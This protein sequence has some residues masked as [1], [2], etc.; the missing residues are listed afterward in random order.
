MHGPEACS[1]QVHAPGASAWVGVGDSLTTSAGTLAARATGGDVTYLV[2]GAIVASASG[3]A[4]VSLP[5]P[6]G[7]CAVVRAIVGRSWS[8]GVYVNCGF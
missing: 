2:N 3:D 1:L 8:S 6:A 4:E 7:R 5:L